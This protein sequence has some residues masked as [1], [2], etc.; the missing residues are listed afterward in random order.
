MVEEAATAAAEEVFVGWVVAVLCIR[1]GGVGGS[2]SGV[3]KK[4]GKDSGNGSDVGRCSDIDCGGGSDSNH[5]SNELHS[6]CP[7]RPLSTS[8]AA[9]IAGSSTLAI[10]LPP[11]TSDIVG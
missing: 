11:P 10:T 6:I 4:K 8:S 7:H 1:I 5:D 2:S 9:A 3:G